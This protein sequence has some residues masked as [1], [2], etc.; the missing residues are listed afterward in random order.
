MD[1]RFNRAT[2]NLLPHTRDD[3]LGLGSRL[4][5]CQRGCALTERVWKRIAID[6][7]IRRGR[8]GIH[9]HE[10]QWSAQIRK[11]LLREF[12]ELARRGFFA[13]RVDKVDDEALFPG[14]VLVDGGRCLLDRG[15]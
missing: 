9:W 14:S 15:V 10:H 5:L 4:R 6:S 1:R 2:E 12:A 13:G 3:A 8:H 11:A 7:A